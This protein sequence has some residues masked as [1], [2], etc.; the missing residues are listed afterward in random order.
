MYDNVGKLLKKTASAVAVLGMVAS[1][2]LGIYVSQNAQFTGFLL[3]M[4]G[5]ACS[6]IAMMPLYCIGEIVECAQQTRETTND[7]L[8]LMMQLAP[9]SVKNLSENDPQEDSDKN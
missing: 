1:F 4:L 6:W 9:D 7:I 3:I 2:A 5:C 8:V